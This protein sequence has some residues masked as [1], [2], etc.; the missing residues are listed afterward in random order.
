M[1]TPPPPEPD[2]SDQPV[3]PRRVVWPSRADDRRRVSDL[4]KLWASVSL[5]GV[6][7]LTSVGI[8]I[9]RRRGRALREQLVP[10]HHPLPLDTAPRP[11]PSQDDDEP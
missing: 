5:A 6:L 8:L 10:D 2:T 4:L 11:R 9:I 3:V 7:V 1:P